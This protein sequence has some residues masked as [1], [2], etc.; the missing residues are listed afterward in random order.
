MSNEHK[1]KVETSDTDTARA[2][3]AGA[4][5]AANRRDVAEPPGPPV[6][7]GY[8]V[9]NGSDHMIGDILPG[10]TLDVSK[11]EQKKLDRLEKSA[12]VRARDLT[13]LKPGDKERVF[14]QPDVP[15]LSRHK[16]DAALEMIR[17]ADDADK[18]RAWVADD[19]RP[20]VQK[21]LRERLGQV[22]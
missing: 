9:Q 13:I 6:G 16:L 11:W 17:N 2:L 7:A 21:A 10:A 15:Q 14:V 1:S 22:K 5:V 12:A 4:M 19:E 20:A 18:L 3:L 8:R